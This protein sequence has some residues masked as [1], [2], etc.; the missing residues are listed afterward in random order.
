MYVHAWII[1]S[2]CLNDLLCITSIISMLFWSA[3]IAPD[4][5]TFFSRTAVLSRCMR[6]PMNRTCSHVA[7]RVPHCPTAGTTVS[8]YS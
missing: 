3:A 2:T 6:W 1:M 5:Q 7:L 8:Q 4:I